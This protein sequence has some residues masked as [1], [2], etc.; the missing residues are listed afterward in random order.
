MKKSGFTLIEVIVSIVLVSVVMVS[1]LG[2][3]IQIRQT[4]TVIHEN[5]D[6]IVYSS[7][8]SRVINND[9]AKNNGIR[10]STCS[11]D[12][13]SCDII[14]GNDEKRKLE[15]LRD[16]SC[17]NLN[18][19]SISCNAN[20]DKK[21]RVK[22]TLKYTNNTDAN[23]NKL[24]YIRTLEMNKSER[25]GQV[26]ASGYGFADMY[27]IS[28]EHDNKNNS[29]PIVD[30]YTTIVIRLNNEINEEISKYDIVL[31]TAGRY[32]YSNL[33]RQVFTLEL[34]TNGAT[35][36]GTTRIDE[37]FG[38][39]YFQTESN[40]TASDRISASKPITVPKNGTQ[41][42]MGYFYYPANSDQKTQVIDSSGNIVLSSRFFRDNVGTNLENDR[43]APRI[44]AEWSDCSDGYKIVNGSCV[45]ETYSID[46]YVDDTKK[47]TKTVT[48]LSLTPNVTVPLKTA[49]QFTGYYSGTTQ[50]NNA[51]GTG[52]LV[53]K[54]KGN[55]QVSATYSLCTNSGYQHATSWANNNN[56]EITACAS[57]YEKKGSGS[58][59]K[60]EPIQ[61][62]VTFNANGGSGLTSSEKYVTY[63]EAYGTLPTINSSS[64]CGGYSFDGWYTASSGG[65]QI[66]S[67]STVSATSSQTLYAHR[68]VNGYQAYTCP[69]GG[70]YNSRTGKCEEADKPFTGYNTYCCRSNGYWGPGDGTDQYCDRNGNNVNYAVTG[71]RWYKVD[72]GCDEYTWDHVEPCDKAHGGP[73][74]AD[75]CEIRTCRA[76]CVFTSYPAELEWFGC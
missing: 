27:T 44:V 6:I 48:Y 53:Y 32:N 23:N 37:V 31:H 43:T 68:S 33:L 35:V 50:Y 64:S 19:E 66:T 7:S 61:I 55:S 1:L 18:G 11:A 14:L 39:G 34:N 21:D 15:I 2:S 71:S 28:Y 46:Y 12:G 13:K 41:A 57:G 10:Y 4:Y 17:T 51:S 8:I 58:A 9:L 26:G 30:Q 38:V 69:D 76:K 73:Y 59:T 65:T 67:A 47:E 3:L 36:A 62:K 25:N 40:H 74:E 24:I 63:G 56:C 54:T 29:N 45:P 72:L 5:S 20:V 49:Y 22:T 42:F 70:T 16:E 60:C 75:E 52:T